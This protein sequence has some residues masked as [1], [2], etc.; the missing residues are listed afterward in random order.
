MQANLSYSDLRNKL[1]KKSENVGNT[2]ENLGSL[3]EHCWR[4]TIHGI[5]VVK[6]GFF[7]LS[8]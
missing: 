5:S 3:M 7:I 4:K 2:T 8:W 1:G 6:I